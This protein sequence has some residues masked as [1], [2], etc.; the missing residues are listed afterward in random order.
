[1]TAFRPSIAAL[2]EVVDVI[3]GY[4]DKIKHIKGLYVNALP[5][6]VY[7]NIIAQMTKRGGNS[8]CIDPQEEPF[9]LFSIA[10]NWDDPAEDAFMSGL[11]EETLRSIEQ[12][13]AK[14]GVAHPYRYFNYAAPWQ[15]GD[16][17]AGYDKLS[18]ERMRQLQREYDSDQVF[19]TGGLNGLG[20]KLNSKEKK[21]SP[22]KDEL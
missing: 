15:A 11:M 4:F 16:V 5:H 3:G 13:A 10:A 7:R 1:M 22:P 20:F 14:H 19:A 12:V 17:W 21:P 2:N 8:L 9:W 6:P 18:L